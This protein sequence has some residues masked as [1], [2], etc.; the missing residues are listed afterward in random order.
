MMDLQ[1]QASGESRI[2]LLSQSVRRL[3]ED[4]NVAESIR[5]EFDLAE[6]EHYPG[7]LEEITLAAK[8]EL[9]QQN[10]IADETHRINEGKLGPEWLP[11][12]SVLLSGPAVLL[13]VQ[14]I[15][16]VAKSALAKERAVRVTLKRGDKECLLTFDNIDAKTVKDILK[17][18][19][20]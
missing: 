18:L 12:L 10:V 14:A 16:D 8:H 3:R 7:E 11:V 17:Q 2:K 15:R 19:D 6:D 4:H 9:E 20:P 5:I 13:A 1:K